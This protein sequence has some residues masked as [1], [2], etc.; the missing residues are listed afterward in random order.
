MFYL[1]RA[2][3]YVMSPMQGYMGYVVLAGLG[4]RYCT[5]KLMQKLRIKHIQVFINTFFLE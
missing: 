5:L 3:F 1:I 2:L 4:R